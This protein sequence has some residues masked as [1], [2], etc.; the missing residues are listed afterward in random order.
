L[1]EKSPS[2]GVKKVYNGQF[3][4]TLVKGSGVFSSLIGQLGIKILT[5]EDFKEE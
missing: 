2:C 4:G 5:E 1:K 3:N